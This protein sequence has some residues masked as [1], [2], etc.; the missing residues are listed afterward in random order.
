MGSRGR[1]RSL[2]IQRPPHPAQALSPGQDVH[3]KQSRKG[4]REA[5]GHSYKTVLWSRYAQPGD[6][7]SILDCLRVPL[8]HHMTPSS[9]KREQAGLII[10]TV[11]IEVLAYVHDRRPSK[12]TRGVGPVR[13]THTCTGRC[14]AAL[15]MP[16]WRWPHLSTSR[17]P[18]QS[19][20]GSLHRPGCNRLTLAPNFVR[21]ALIVRL[22]RADAAD[23][24]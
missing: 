11:K 21:F 13:H 1:F 23:L 22:D 24:W 8:V 10:K 12:Q 20:R 5:L 14:L 7:F 15:A 3:G 19:E 18:Q 9:I 2:Q 16:D 6:S 17:R 4:E